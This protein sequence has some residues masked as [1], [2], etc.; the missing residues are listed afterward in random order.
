M[1]ITLLSILAI[2]CIFLKI[3]KNNKDYE[4]WDDFCGWGFI[5]FMSCCLMLIAHALTYPVKLERPVVTTTQKIVA[6]KQNSKTEGEFRGGLFF[7]RCRIEEVD[8][9]VC[10]TENNGVYRQENFPVEN[11]VVKE[12][13]GQPRVVK[14]EKFVQNAIPGWI[15][16]HFDEP[17]KIHESDTI[18][19]PEG[20][21]SSCTKFEVF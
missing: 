4:Y 10:L 1:I 21:V 20:T 5:I 6:M 14:S 16:F 2:V 13:S 12:T 7:Y 11:T 18:F 15:R 3:R 8:Y 17:K 9:Y 19:V